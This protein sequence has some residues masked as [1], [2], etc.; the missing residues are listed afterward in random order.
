MSKS[1]LLLLVLQPYVKKKYIYIYILMISGSAKQKIE[2]CVTI[3]GLELKRNSHEIFMDW[4]EGYDSFR[5]EEVL[6]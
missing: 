4:K 2:N 6:S 5:K 3:E 1:G